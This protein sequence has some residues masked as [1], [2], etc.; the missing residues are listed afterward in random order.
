LAKGTATS[1]V[2]I[3][4]EAEAEAETIS[5]VLAVA[6]HRGGTLTKVTYRI[7]GLAV[8][9]AETTY[10]NS[11]KSTTFII[12]KAAGLHN[13]LQKNRDVPEAVLLYTQN[14]IAKTR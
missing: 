11:L 12:K 9:T 2:D 14:S 6:T 1:T 5:I 7:K 8:D 13:T 10:N 3:D 4:S